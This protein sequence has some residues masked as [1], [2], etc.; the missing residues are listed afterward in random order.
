[1]TLVHDQGS[2]WPGFGYSADEQA[3]LRTIAR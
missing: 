3:A 2:A 1:M